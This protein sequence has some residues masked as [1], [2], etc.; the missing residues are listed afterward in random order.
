MDSFADIISAFGGPAAFAKAIGIEPSHAGS[1]KTRGSIPCEYWSDVVRAGRQLG[2]AGVSLERL[3]EIAAHRRAGGACSPA[4]Q[5][6]Q[7]V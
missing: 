5:A 6:G 2:I 3:A 1:M 7:A 4:A